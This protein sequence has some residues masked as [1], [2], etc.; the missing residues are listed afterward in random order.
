[1]TPGVTAIKVKIR[2]TC[3][4]ESATHSDEGNLYPENNVQGID[5]VPAITGPGGQTDSITYTFVEGINENLEIYTSSG[6]EALTATV[7]FCIEVGLYATDVL[8]NFAEV[9]MNYNIDLDTT[10]ATLTG[11]TVTQADSYTA[12][13][14]GTLEFDGTLSS[15][16]CNP[17][18]NS[19]L[20]DD[21]SIIHQGSVMSVCIIADG[22]QFQVRDVIDMK[23]NN[24]IGTFLPEQQ[25]WF[26]SAPAETGYAERTCTDASAIDVNVCVVSFL[27]KAIFFE[28]SALDLSGSGSVLL[29]LGDNTGGVRG[30]RILRRDLV[31]REEQTSGTV[32]FEVRPHPV[33]LDQTTNEGS[34]ATSA[35]S[36]LTAFAAM[37][38]AALIL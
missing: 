33:Y 11:Y 30:R 3:R 1:L 9:K 8:I 15:Y 7:N 38:G 28:F 16:F 23:I 17:I 18:D 35:T 34:S 14:Q 5:A 32:A 24:A 19:V 22:G 6:P 13:D 29:E 31:L 27:L 25:V 36:S 12:D 10:F 20:I 26:N 21:G 37:A 2:D 4:T